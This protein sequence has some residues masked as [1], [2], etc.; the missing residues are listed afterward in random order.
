M[1]KSFIESIQSPK[2]RCYHA[3]MNKNR[4]KKKKKKMRTNITLLQWGF[5]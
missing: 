5:I 1:G 4:K 3:M 2:L